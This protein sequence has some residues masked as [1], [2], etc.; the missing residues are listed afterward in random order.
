MLNYISINASLEKTLFHSSV[1][2]EVASRPYCPCILE[3]KMTMMMKID[4]FL[5]AV[6]YY[7]FKALSYFAN[8]HM[9]GLHLY[10]SRALLS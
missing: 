8:L 1:D 4:S 3:D 7:N 9:S 6:L 2:H 5:K 10:G